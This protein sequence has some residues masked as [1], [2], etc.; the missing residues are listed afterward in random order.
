M[1]RS[2]TQLYLFSECVVKKWCKR[3]LEGDKGDAV[4]HLFLRQE[5]METAGDLSV[6]SCASR[7][8]PWMSRVKPLNWPITTLVALYAYEVGL[9][10]WNA[11]YLIGVL[12]LGREN[13]D[14]PSTSSRKQL[15][16]C[17][18]QESTTCC[19]PASPRQG[20]AVASLCLGLELVP[21]LSSPSSTLDYSLLLY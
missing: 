8:K 19:V 3:M 17:R 5:F 11:C 12:H 16:P 14:A 6:G 20:E 1:N 18:P 7:P 10:S 4:S 21:S 13:R 15:D 9:T 2:Y